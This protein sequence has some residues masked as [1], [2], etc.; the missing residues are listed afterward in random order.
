MISDG[1]TSKLK[2]ILDK[3]LSDLPQKRYVRVIATFS[4]VD[5]AE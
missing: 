3:G 2:E 1:V 4:G 5:K